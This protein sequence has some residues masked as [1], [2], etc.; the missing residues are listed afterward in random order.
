MEEL[1]RHERRRV[2]GARRQLVI[3]GGGVAGLSAWRAALKRGLDVVLVEKNAQLGGLTRS[4][5]VNDFVFDYTGHFLHLAHFEA[6][7]DVWGGGGGAG[8]AGAGGWRRVQRGSACRVGGRPVPAPVQYHLGWLT[9]PARTQ[10]VAGYRAAVAAGGSRGKAAGGPAAVPGRLRRGEEGGGGGAAA[11]GE[12]LLSYFYRS[13]GEGITRWFLEPYNRKLLATD[14][15]NLS[16]ESLNRFFPAPD[17]VLMEAGIAG[18]GDSS[19]AGSTAADGGAT[20]NSRFWYPESDGIGQLV[21]QLDPG[22]FWV[23]D[24]VIAIDPVARVVRTRGQEIPYEHVISTLPLPD[25]LRMCVAGSTAGGTATTVG[26]GT[27]AADRLSAAGVA[28]FQV[29]LRGGCPDLLR[30]LH[31][32][33]VPDPD[34]VFHRVGVYSNIHGNMA[35]AGCFSLYVEVGL[36]HGKTPNWEEL[37]RRVT[38]D[39]EKLEIARRAQVEVSVRHAIRPG[40][41]HFDHA[42][43]N[44]VPT[45]VREL[46]DAGVRCVGRYGRWDYISMED[47]IREAAVVVG[48]IVGDV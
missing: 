24:E 8:G 42:W 27:A 16:A 17:P 18:G 34:I 33:Y 41:V 20:Y 21:R 2:P 6:P 38:G 47:A 46:A 44:L 26:G 10:C 25:L 1:V 7:G 11:A 29:G 9:E 36:E 32:L 23:Q 30:D 5:Y 13:F 4:I 31:W 48:D 15:R 19:G 12:D 35:P 37:E 14:L 40:Y 45:A 22:L 39:L 43:K 28:A 3:L